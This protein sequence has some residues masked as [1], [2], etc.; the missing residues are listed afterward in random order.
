MARY[1]GPVCR[2]CRREGEK[3]FLKGDRCFSSKCALDRR[4]S[5]PGQH[6]KS[7]GAFSEYKIQLREK[8]KVKRIYGL[9]EKQFRKFFH[10]AERQ[11]GVTGERLLQELE[12]RLDNMVYRSGFAGSRKEARQFVT[13]GHFLVNGKVVNVPSYLVKAGDTISL[14]ERGRKFNRV[15]ETIATA[16]VRK[17]PDWIE[18]DKENYQARVKALPTRS[19]LPATIKE[20]LIVELYSK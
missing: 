4:Q 6:A 7:R 8:Q 15:N 9:L 13:H 11:K 10:K 5:S 16:E 19:E 1:T 3:L 20:Q 2:L 12:A 14:I 18:F 17:L